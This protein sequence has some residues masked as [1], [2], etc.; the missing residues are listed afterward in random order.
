MRDL[1]DSQWGKHDET[2]CQEDYTSLLD[3]AETGKRITYNPSSIMTE[4]SNFPSLLA[5]AKGE[6]SSI[7]NFDPVIKATVLAQLFKEE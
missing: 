1:I 5:A 6:I 7:T 3:A 2:I 4:L